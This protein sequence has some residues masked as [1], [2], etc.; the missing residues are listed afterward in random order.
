MAHDKREGM[1][2][3]IIN[4]TVPSI[5]QVRDKVQGKKGLAETAPSG[6]VSE[7][8]ISSHYLSA[9]RLVYLDYSASGWYLAQ[10]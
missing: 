1:G 9:R 5:G 7:C 3:C 2:K 4:I 10:K 8:C 6:R